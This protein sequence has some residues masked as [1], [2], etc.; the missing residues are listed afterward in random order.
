MW[1]QGGLGLPVA[2]PHRARPYG[3][4]CGTTGPVDRRRAWPEHDD[5]GVERPSDPPNSEGARRGV[6]TVNQQQI[7]RVTGAPS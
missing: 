4:T 1:L 6:G 5:Q 2:R 3:W 7:E